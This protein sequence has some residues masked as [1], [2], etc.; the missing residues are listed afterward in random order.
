[1]ST[2]HNKFDLFEVYYGGAP[3]SLL[4]PRCVQTLAPVFLGH[5]YKKTSAK[6]PSKMALW[7]VTLEFIIMLHD[8]MSHATSLC[9]NKITNFDH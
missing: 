8:V 7:T 4:A 5:K 9:V 6:A 2:I 3:Y 1:M